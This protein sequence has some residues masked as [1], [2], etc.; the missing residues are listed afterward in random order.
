MLSARG[1]KRLIVLL[2]L[3]SACRGRSTTA[4]SS[5]VSG[6]TFATTA[7]TASTIATTVVS[8]TTT[9]SHPPV[10]RRLPV[11]PPP[12]PPPCPQTLAGQLAS[13]GAASQLITVD[14]PSSASTTATLALW[15][16]TGSCW[17]LTAGPWTGWTGRNG[18]SDHHRE[19][20]GTTPTGAYSIGT[21]IYGIAANPGVNYS[22]HQLVCG[23]WW[24]EDSS[25]PGYNTFQHVPCGTAPPFGGGSEALWTETT[26]YQNFAV[27]D[28]NTH[29]AVPGAGSAIFL[30]DDVGGPT[31]G[32]VTLPAGQLAVLLRWLDPAHSPLIVIGTD[33][34]IRRF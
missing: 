25:T 4:V 5:A 17:R 26:A 27:V 19:G 1:R 12:P 18:L 13:T 22:Y 30:H 15:Q 21:V 16:R 24:D 2:V 11:P 10:T 34:T 33:A 20:D 6:T 14:A 32:C 7:M 9:T 31:N 28:Y 8:T 23:D 29:P 3:A